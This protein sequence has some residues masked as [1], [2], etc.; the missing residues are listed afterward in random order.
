MDADVPPV[1]LED[2][3]DHGAPHP[4]VA[5][6]EAVEAG[7]QLGTVE[8]DLVTEGVDVEPQAGLEE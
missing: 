1:A 6:G 8:A 7:G 5:E 3:I 2:Q 4:E